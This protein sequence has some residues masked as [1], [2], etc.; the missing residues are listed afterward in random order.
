M[1]SKIIDEDMDIIFSSCNFEELRNKSILLNGANGMIAT[2]LVYFFIYLNEVK[3]YNIQIYAGVR[4]IEKTK[5]KYG[6]FSKRDYFHIL[7][8]DSCRSDISLT[9]DVDYVIHAA[10]LASPQYYGSNPVETMLPNIVGLN[11]LLKYSVEHKVKSFLFFSS[12]AVYGSMKDMKI[13]SEDFSGDLSFLS[14]NSVYGESKRAGEA[15]GNA[16]YREYNVPFKSV[17]LVHTYGPTMDIVHD[18]RAFSEFVSCILNKKDIVL[19]SE[20]VTKRFFC[21]ITDAVTNL[22]IILLNGKNGESYNFA[23]IYQGETIAGLANRLINLYP[24]RNIHLIKDIPSKTVLDLPPDD[25]TV[26][27]ISKMESL[28]CKFNIS[29]DEGF[30]RVIDHFISLKEG[31]TN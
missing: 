19:R 22:L 27:D 28:G 14:P 3:N 6:E 9:E 15:L 20:G 1:F 31:G 8:I 17:R 5:Q 18:K 2:Y 16:Y 30:K 26:F 29:I 23:N 12:G 7:Q 21:Y 11:V 24:E 4:N 10:S 13:V 25:L